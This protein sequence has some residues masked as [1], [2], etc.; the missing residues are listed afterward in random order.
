MLTRFGAQD[1]DQTTGGIIDFGLNEHSPDL[2]TNRA[3]GL[4]STST[5]GST[6]MALK[7]VNTSGKR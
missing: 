1:G 2:G 5:T 3:L 7:L 4:M 6:T